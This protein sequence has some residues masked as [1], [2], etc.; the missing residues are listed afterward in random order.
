MFVIRPANSSLRSRDERSFKDALGYFAAIIWA[1]A[2]L[3]FFREQLLGA[4][5]ADRRHR[6]HLKFVRNAQLDS[7]AFIIEAFHSVHHEVLPETLQREI[8]PCRASVV[9]MGDGWFVIIFECLSRNEQDENGGI[10]RP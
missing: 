3:Q 9:G 8:L 1:L 4:G 10:L 7:C 5:S 2:L 6:L